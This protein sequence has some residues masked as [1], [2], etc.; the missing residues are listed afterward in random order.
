VSKWKTKLVAV[1]AVT[2]WRSREPEVLMGRWVHRVAV[3]VV[4][5]VLASVLGVGPAAAQEA[6]DN[7]GPAVGA[8]ATS[9]V[10]EVLVPEVINHNSP[11]L[12]AR[13]PG[14]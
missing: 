9:P 2:A 5:A 10:P 8:P 1:L 7:L 3:L 6:P 12:T 4:L 13:P 14:R 11:G